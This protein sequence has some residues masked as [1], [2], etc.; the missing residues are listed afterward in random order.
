MFMICFSLVA[1]AIMCWACDA[2]DIIFVLPLG[3]ITCIA[4]SFELYHVYHQA[5][6][7][8][9]ADSFRGGKFIRAIK[10]VIAV[11]F[12]LATVTSYIVI[13]RFRLDL[14]WSF[15]A[16]YYSFVAICSLIVFIVTPQDP[17]FKHKVDKSLWL[18]TMQKDP[19]TS[20]VTEE[21]YLKSRVDEDW[22]G[23]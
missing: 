12:H 23:M 16:A 19:L 14:V 13:I 4:V 8:E 3:C 15:S 5:V 6:T 20:D 21:V 10:F 11:C 9:A 18:D 22:Y 17:D 1:L 2:G 7:Q